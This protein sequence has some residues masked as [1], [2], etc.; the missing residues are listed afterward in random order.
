MS[1]T[2]SMQEG[3]QQRENFSARPL[4]RAWEPPRL[5]RVGHVAEILQLGGG[6]LSPLAVDSGEPRKTQPSG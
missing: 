1:T 4:P 2:Q 5:S 3:D 6:K